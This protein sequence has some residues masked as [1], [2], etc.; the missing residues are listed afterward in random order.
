MLSIPNFPAIVICISPTQDG[1][2]MAGSINGIGTTFYGQGDFHPDGS[3]ITTKWVIFAFIPIVPTSSLRVRYLGR[4]GWF[5][6]T[7]EFAVEGD[8]PLEIVQVLKTYLYVALL[9][10]MFALLDSKLPPAVKFVTFFGVVILPHILRWFAKKAATEGPAPRTTAT[11][12]P[13]AP[14][15]PILRLQTCPKCHYTRQPHDH[16]PDWQCPSC[17][18]AYNKVTPEALAARAQNNS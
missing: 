13:S 3:F 4:S 16:A 10:G 7:T 11:R 6:N 12:A 2:A 15:A 18:V 14:A 9:F 8:V 17:Q 1:I 5:S